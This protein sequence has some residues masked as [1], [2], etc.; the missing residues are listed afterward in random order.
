LLSDTILVTCAPVR[1]NFHEE[2]WN[3]DRFTIGFLV[4][5]ALPGAS[6]AFRK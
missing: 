5:Q 3:F 6:K 2:N 4:P 1:I